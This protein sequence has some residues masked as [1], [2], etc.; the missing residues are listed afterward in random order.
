MGS[1]LEIV[2]APSIKISGKAPLPLNQVA[3]YR[4]LE[5]VFSAPLIDACPRRDLIRIACA[6]PRSPGTGS[7]LD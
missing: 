4:G 7:V 3:I 6:A 5:Q 1:E 2:H